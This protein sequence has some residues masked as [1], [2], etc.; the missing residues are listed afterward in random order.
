MK[1]YYNKLIFIIILCLNFVILNATTSYAN[2]NNKNDDDKEFIQA[3]TINPQELNNVQN[4]SYDEGVTIKEIDVR[5]N[6]LITSDAIKAKLN[7]KVG[8]K[9]DKNTVQQDL[10]SIY[11]MGY[12][13]DKLK[14]V[15]ESSSDGIKLRIEVEE[16]APV[17]GFNISGNKVISTADLAKIFN[18]QTGLP[19][20]IEELNKSVEDI[21]KLYASKGYVL[22]RV[23]K[24]YDDPDGMINIEINE[25]VID[26]VKITGNVKTKDFVIKRNMLTSSG[27]V[28]NENILKQDLSRLYNTQSFSD[29]RRV[30]TASPTDPDK[31]QLT[32]EVDEKRT[33]TIS[34]GGGVDTNSGVFGSLGYNDPNFKGNGQQVSVAGSLGTGMLL[35]NSDTIKRT[36]MQLEANFVEPRFKQ[37][38]NSLSLSAFAR[39]YASYQVPLGIERRIGSEIAVSR[40]IK[41]VPHLAGSVSMGVENVN[42]SEGDYDSIADLFARKG[43]NIGE[44]AKELQ[45]GTFVSLGP[46]LVY[47]T[48][49]NVLNPTSGWYASSSLKGSMAVAGD[50]GSFGTLDASVRRYIPIGQKSTF[51]IGAKAGT[52]LIG[53]MPEFATFRLGGSST[54]RGFREGMVGNGRG[55]ML[56]SA[57]LRTPIPFVD[58]ITKI[59]F[60]NSMRTAFFLDAGSIFK[61]STT[62]YLFDKPGYALSAGMGLRLN[63]PGLGPVKIDYGVPLTSISGKRTGRFSFGFGD[64]W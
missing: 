32:V 17:T 36:S 38:L 21:E 9:F 4:K 7:L 63:M 20:N 34:V 16:N 57:E 41:K 14:A 10:Q 55:F 56:A 18:S 35:S 15:P 53:D 60:I 28:Y 6:H 50:S 27:T 29:V 13:T 19:Q 64:R 26:K 52:N 8:S 48:R 54:V 46:S 30:I 11:N 49:N 25:G 22:A 24:I 23:K 58:K 43:V 37:T 2:N 40:P 12:F 1:F 5:G 61:E 33:G 59:N 31:Y 39:D 3:N 44:R 42:V 47:D 51:T 62:D 45:G